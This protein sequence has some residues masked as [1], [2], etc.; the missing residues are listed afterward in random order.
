MATRRDIREAFYAELESAAA[1]HVAADNIRGENPESE[2]QLPSIVH[3][4]AYRKRPI[5]MASDAPIDVQR[6]MSGDATAE[7]HGS[8]HDAQ[9]SL[10]LWFTD[11]DAKEDCYE[12]VR[13]YFEKY[14]VSSSTWDPADI[15]S[16]V[17]WVRVED[18]T[19]Q[20]D[21]DIDPVR[22]GDRLLVQ[23]TFLRTYDNTGTAVQSVTTDVDADN[24]GTTDATWTSS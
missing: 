5:N 6:D 22:H 10:L 15:Q 20:N 11:E 24:D 14:E 3:D 16:D 12:A 23:L 19:S 4:D 9:F 13:S 1:G 21:E 2:E 7:T 17:K 18:A 8:L